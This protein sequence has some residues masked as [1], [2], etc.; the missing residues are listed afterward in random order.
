[1]SLLIL[2]WAIGVLI[3]WFIAIYK[4]FK[5]TFSKEEQ[6]EEENHSTDDWGDF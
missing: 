3:I 4:L 2:I 1:M 6:N 5:L